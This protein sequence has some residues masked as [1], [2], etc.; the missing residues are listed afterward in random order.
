DL[1]WWEVGTGRETRRLAGRLD[2]LCRL[3]V[4]PDGRRLAAV[5]RPG[6]L[7]L[8]NAASGEEVSR[9]VLGPGGIWCLCFSPDGRTLACSGG[10][11][12]RPR[13]TP[14]TRF[15]AA[16]TGRELRRWDDDCS[17]CHLAFSPDGKVLAQVARYRI[18]LRDAAT[19]RPALR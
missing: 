16:D 8:W 1:R 2:H 19:G 17:I 18:Q 10:V 15:F 6:T 13:E 9:T 4:S 14:Q 12:G 5:V 7:H 11:A 3:T